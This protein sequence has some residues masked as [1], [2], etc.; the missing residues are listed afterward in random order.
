MQQRLD[1]GFVLKRF[2]TG[3]VVVASYHPVI[4]PLFWDVSRSIRF[5]ESTH[6]G[7]TT[8]IDR[9]HRFER[10]AASNEA[11]L[12]RIL[13][14]NLDTGELTVRTSAEAGC[15][16]VGGDFIALG[17]LAAVSPAALVD[18]TI[19]TAWIEV[20]A[21]SA[22]YFLRRFE[23]SIGPFAEWTRDVVRAHRFSTSEVLLS[24]ELDSARA[25]GR[26][27]PTSR[28]AIESPTRKV[29]PIRWVN[30]ALEADAAWSLW[31]LSLR[32]GFVD[33]KARRQAL[34]HAGMAG[35][36]FAASMSAGAISGHVAAF[37]DL[38][39]AFETGRALYFSVQKLLANGQG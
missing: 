39:E 33:A 38:R 11:V 30:H 5:G 7:L 28:A 24:R 27:V 15:R 16:M 6:Y 32:F 3:S 29:G 23:G 18:W 12:Q 31:R 21:P 36:Q 1:D 37:P 9:A 17:D 34:R 35:W 10:D 8:E 2:V 13:D 26:F 22:P 25:Y 20:P 4:G 19:T 14:C